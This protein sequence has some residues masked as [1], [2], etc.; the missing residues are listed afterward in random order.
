[1][2]LDMLLGKDDFEVGEREGF[3]E[4]LRSQKDLESTPK[5]SGL[6]QDKL[7]TLQG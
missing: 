5:N 7:I 4:I 1:M 3:Y 2:K 6:S